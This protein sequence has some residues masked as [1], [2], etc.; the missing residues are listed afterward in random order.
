M[1]KRTGMKMEV[2]VL[3]VGWAIA[4]AASVATVIALVLLAWIGGEL[5]YRNCL[6]NAELRYPVAYQPGPAN[7]FADPHAHFVFYK[8]AQR[9]RAIFGCSRWP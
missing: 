5:H 4:L 3:S 6:Q 8:Q 9:D 2:D 1:P 7:R